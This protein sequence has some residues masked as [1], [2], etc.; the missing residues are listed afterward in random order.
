MPY[1]IRRTGFFALL[2]FIIII[3][4][5]SGFAQELKI[6]GASTIQPILEALAPLARERMSLELHIQG[7]GSGAG[8][9]DAQSGESDIGVVSR[10]LTAEELGRF[11]SQVIGLDALVFITNEGNSISAVTKQQVIDLF[12]GK[13]T[14]WSSL[15]GA[16]ADVVLITIE[17]GRSTLELIEDYTGLASPHRSISG[18]P[19]IATTAHETGSNLEVVTLVAGLPNAIGYVS[20][21]SAQT[22]HDMGMP[23][24]ILNLEGS[25]PSKEAIVERSYPIV[26]ELNLVFQEQTEDI[27]SLL[28]LIA[29]TDGQEVILQEGFIPNN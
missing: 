26:R 6:S 4:T 14:N 23:I 5:A 10:N 18:R 1:T 20:F 13:T 27:R 22:M 7:G 19:T 9:R 29:S 12:S 17:L 3:G 28:Q 25:V 8:I 16:D 2:L 21:G 15:G 11:N 24:K